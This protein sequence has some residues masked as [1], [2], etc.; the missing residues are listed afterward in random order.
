MGFARRTGPGN[1]RTGAVTVNFTGFP[2]ASNEILAANTPQGPWTNI[3]TIVSDGLGA[4]SFTD[5]NRAGRQSR[6]YRGAAVP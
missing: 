2:N 3:A 5:T 4:F 1:R 6:F